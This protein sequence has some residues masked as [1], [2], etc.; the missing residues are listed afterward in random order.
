MRILLD[1][2]MIV[3]LSSRMGLLP[4]YARKLVEDDRNEIFFS[5]VSIWEIAIKD[6]LLRDEITGDAEKVRDGLVKN[7]F[8]ELALCSRHAFEL[9][10]L[11]NLHRDP[12][13]RI[14]IAQSRAERLT[15]LT[16]DET[17][18]K[19]PGEMIFAKKK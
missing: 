19:Y 18:F 10:K 3:W 12:F 15:L 16:S 2:N 17:I 14:L 7:N 11:P 6:V 9:G 13:D 5:A 4:P 1:T 8:E